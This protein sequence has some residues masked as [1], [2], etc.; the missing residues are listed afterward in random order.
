[1]SS[2]NEPKQGLSADE[3]ARTVGEYKRQTGKPHPLIRLARALAR[4]AALARH[5][6]VLAEAQR[7]RM[8]QAD[9]PLTWSRGDS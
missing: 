8:E 2:D 1:M 9:T 4:Q 6:A 5:E 3:F 7:K